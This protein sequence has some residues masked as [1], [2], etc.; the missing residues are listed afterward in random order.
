MGYCRP[1]AAVVVAVGHAQPRTGPY[2][3]G[4]SHGGCSPGGAGR[5]AVGALGKSTCGLRV[6]IGLSSGALVRTTGSGVGVRGV[7]GGCSRCWPRGQAAPYA[8]AYGLSVGA[9]VPAVRFGLLF[10]TVPACLTPERLISASSCCAV[11]EPWA[12]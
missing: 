1:V 4:N 10:P 7:V 8:A 5:E 11:V 6:Y 2:A 12:L 3:A 9:V